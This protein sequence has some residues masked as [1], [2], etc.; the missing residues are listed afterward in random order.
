MTPRALWRLYVTL[1]AMLSMVLLMATA[2][3]HLHKTEQA[4]QEC[5][6][7]CG[8]IDKLADLPVPLAIVVTTAQLLPYLLLTAA[9]PALVPRSAIFLPPNRGPPASA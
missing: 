2:S 4:A 1:V 7:C 3:T 6:L 9:P 8:V 5:A